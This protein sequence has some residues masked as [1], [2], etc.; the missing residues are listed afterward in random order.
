MCSVLTLPAERTF[1]QMFNKRGYDIDVDNTAIGGTT[2]EYWARNP[3]S[4]LK[5]V[6]ANPDCKWVWLSIGGNDGIYGLSDGEPIEEVIARTINNT[7]VFLDP[8]FAAL[9]N[10]QVVQFGYDIVDFGH[11]T[12]CRN[13]GDDLFPW[14]STTACKNNEMFKL[15]YDYVDVRPPPRAL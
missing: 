1:Q 15:Q 7:Q 9:P 8:L 5:R 2:A 11:S 10:I 12:S 14:C 6:Q 13:L 4:L 3:D